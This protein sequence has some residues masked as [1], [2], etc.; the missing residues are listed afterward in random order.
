VVIL[1][2]YAGNDL[3]GVYDYM[4]YANDRR[5]VS[6]D[7]ADQISGAE[8]AY[9][10]FL[11]SIAGRNSYALNVGLSG[12]RYARMFAIRR[13]ARSDI[14]ESQAHPINPQIDFFYDLVFEDRIIPFN[15][16]NSDTDEVIFAQLLRDG[17]IKLAWVDLAFRELQ[18][19]SREY[20]F[21]PIIVFVPSAHITYKS[22][23]SFR[24]PTLR[25]LL[26][27]YNDEQRDYL[28]RLASGLSIPFLDLTDGLTDASEN[29]YPE[30]LYFPIN[31]HF[32]PAG[33]RE[34]ARIVRSWMSAQSVSRL[35]PAK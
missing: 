18:K 15:P 25:E 10:Y 4:V 7:D 5:K 26:N 9:N 2:Y 12:I 30:L 22:H 14:A 20:G 13:L 32:S 24:D 3:R 11:Y 31:L 34:V 6:D 17:Q 35:R 16:Q 19:L 33:H 29:V 1:A 21:Q 28:A 27:W 23:V 8:S